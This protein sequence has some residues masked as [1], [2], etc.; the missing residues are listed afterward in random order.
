MTGQLNIT[1]PDDLIEFM[2]AKVRSGEYASEADVALEGIA[3]LRDRD[4]SIED[5]LRDEVVPACDA[6][7]ADP[8][9]ALSIE[10]VRSALAAAHERAIAAQ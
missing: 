9:Q 1:L 5:W 8:S 7:M 3:F 6:H 2:Q 10:E 4:L